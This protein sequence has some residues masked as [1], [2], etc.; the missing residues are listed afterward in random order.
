MRRAAA[1]LPRHARYGNNNILESK[2]INPAIISGWTAA[3]ADRECEH[4]APR[5]WLLLLLRAGVTGRDTQSLGV[6]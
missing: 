1:S 6:P 4:G 5:A 3:T 2:V